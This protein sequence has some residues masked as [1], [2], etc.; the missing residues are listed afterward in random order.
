[1]KEM[2]SKEMETMA[3]YDMEAAEAGIIACLFPLSLR[4]I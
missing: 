4:S 3:C 1:M 2:D